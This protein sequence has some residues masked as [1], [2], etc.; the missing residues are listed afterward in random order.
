MEDFLKE[1]KLCPHA[2]K[3]N[4]LDEKQEDVEQGKMLNLH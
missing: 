4:R 3:V 2:C 1:C